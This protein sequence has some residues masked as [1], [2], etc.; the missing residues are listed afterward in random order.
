MIIRPFNFTCQRDWRS[1]ELLVRSWRRFS[2]EPWTIYFDPTQP[3]TERM[4]AF[5]QE[6]GVTLRLQ[7]RKDFGQWCWDSSMCKLDAWREMASDP[8]LSDDDWLIYSDS[9][10]M[11]HSP[12]VK[13]E[14][15]GDF[16][17]FPH[18]ITYPVPSLNTDHWTFFSG[19]LQAG[20]VGVVRKMGALPD[21]RL[22]QIKQEMLTLNFS[23]NEDV[24]ISFLMAQVGAVYRP[25]PGGGEPNPEGVLLGTKK[26][27]RPFSH[28]Y[29]GFTSFCGV[30][31]TGKW[32]IPLALEKLGIKI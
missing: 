15:A 31:V 32:D 26:A 24:V 19:C 28:M 12:E 27:E 18:S 9:D 11:F 6:N 2:P 23:H 16:C 22:E 5:C 10:A 1:S 4:T 13:N 3:I 20:R 30:P 21:P 29:G 7:S 17:G 14:L 25:F 8:A